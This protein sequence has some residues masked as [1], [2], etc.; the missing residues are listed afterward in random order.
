MKKIVFLTCLLLGLNIKAQII[1][2]QN[3]EGPL[4]GTYASNI[5]Y[6]NYPQASYSAGGQS[7]HG[8]LL[9]FDFSRASSAIHLYSPQFSKPNVQYYVSYWLNDYGSNS[10]IDVDLM[11]QPNPAFAGQSVLDFTVPA[12]NLNEWTYI[13]HIIPSGYY[14]ETTYFIKWESSGTILVDDIYISQNS[15]TSIQEEN[16]SRYFKVYP[17]PS[18]TGE[19]NVAVAKAFENLDC[20]IFNSVGKVVYHENFSSA[21]NESKKINTNTLEKGVYFIKIA[22]ENSLFQSKIIIQ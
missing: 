13:E 16:F 19:I 8:G 22:N 18:N 15:I 11:K 6:A 20:T 4:S 10:Y 9:M 17:N 14:Q 21:A 3:F 12:T 1:S 2:S 7:P 5:W